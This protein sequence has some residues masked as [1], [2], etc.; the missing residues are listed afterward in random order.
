M[1]VYFKKSNFA[2]IIFVLY[3]DMCNKF[4]SKG[5]KTQISKYRPGAGAFIA[6][7]NLKEKYIYETI[8]L[9]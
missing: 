6:G 3:L 5:E 8:G 7:K 4:I 1:Y 2:K 9:D